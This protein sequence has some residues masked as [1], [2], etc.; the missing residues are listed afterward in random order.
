MVNS[1]IESELSVL[2]YENQ[3]LEAY[4][5]A[6]AEIQKEMNNFFLKYQDKNGK[7]P[8]ATAR[9]L[10]TSAERKEFNSYL[11]SWY[12]E[13]RQNG[14]PESYK[15]YLE[16]LG[17]KTQISRLETLEASIKAQIERLKTNQYVDVATLLSINYTAA[18]FKSYYTVASGAEM[19]VRFNN[20]SA[21]G[22]EKAIKT[23]VDG[24]N[25]SD[26]IWNDKDKLEATLKTVLPQSF[27]RGLSS[28]QIG[29]IIAREMN[30]SKN[31]GR[32]LARTEVNNLCNQASL[33]VYKAVGLK[34][35]EFLATL[36]MRTSE[37]CRSLDGKVFKVSQAQNGVNHPPMHPNCRSTTI[38]VIDSE[39][40]EDRIARDEDGDNIKVPRNMTQEQY[41]KKY[42]PEDMQDKLLS[43]LKK[44][45]FE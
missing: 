29:D 44:Y 43:F 35:Y 34:E 22:V 19:T 5:L 14:M 21:V 2:D 4:E 7:I 15:K 16:T 13:A 41:I 17:K 33:D 9:K 39:E 36:D 28:K 26:R 30:A 40:I 12:A 8:Y 42:A 25:F 1:I 20:V 23:K 45:K 18:Y 27:S 6:L 31:R 3:M 10:L 38:P 24:A 11:K 37:I 32:T